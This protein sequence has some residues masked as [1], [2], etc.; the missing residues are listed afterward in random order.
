MRNCKYINHVIEEARP[1]IWWIGYLVCDP[2]LRE[3]QRKDKFD[4]F[5][6]EIQDMNFQGLP[7]VYN[8][9]KKR[10]P[11]GRVVFAWHDHNFPATDTFAVAFLA[12]ITNKSILR[13]PAC[14]T[15]LGDSNVSLSTYECDRS[16]AVEVSITFCGARDGCVGMFVPQ[17][18]LSEMMKKFGFISDYKPGEVGRICASY[19][20]TDITGKG[21]EA[22]PDKAIQDEVLSLNSVLKE[23]P[24]MQYRVIVDSMARDHKSV[25]ELSQKVEDYNEVVGLLSD[26]LSSMIQS[27]LALEEGSQSPIALK[28]RRDMEIMRKK[29]V[30]D[31]GSSDMAA[32]REMVRYCAECFPDGGDGI[33]GEVVAK[34]CTM[35]DRKFPELG[36]KLENRSS[37]LS[38]T[39]D[40][41]FDI[42]RDEMRERELF[43]LAKQRQDTDKR[44]KATDVARKQFDL[45][46]RKGYKPLSTGN[47]K[48]NGPS[49]D[50]HADMSFEDF[51]K[52]VGIPS[53]DP[54]ERDEV[55]HW[56]QG[57]T[58]KRIKLGSND[59]GIDANDPEEFIKYAVKRENGRQQIRKR[60]D[61]YKRDYTEHKRRKIDDEKRKLEQLFEYVP[62]LTE[63]ARHFKDKMSQRPD[64]S[65]NTVGSSDKE[66]DGTSTDHT[67]SGQRMP[68]AVG[69]EKQTVDASHETEHVKD[70]E[71]LFDL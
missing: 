15:V 47:T 44:R 42:I 65:I 40:A 8:H 31:Q 16:K 70:S 25:S 71:I 68:P 50:S 2:K 33:E 10:R 67:A 43:K 24:E 61:A 14:I 32:I 51:M 19:M 1:G 66:R 22:E 9:N 13:T 35:F 4:L 59:T 60:F 52:A 37:S 21:S 23:L 55:G 6:D 45:F 41:A 53:D 63:M 30:I 36:E 58:G 38:T 46:S 18:R 29:G 39:I 26:Y 57:Y 12:R 54:L 49:K 69:S 7:V 34:F 27:R 62:T 3:R 48:E 11:L 20:M 17:D 5:T 28:R 64:L 56:G